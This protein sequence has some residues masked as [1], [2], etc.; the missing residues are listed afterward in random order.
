MNKSSQQSAQVSPCVLGLKRAANLLV[1]PAVGYVNSIWLLNCFVTTNLL[2]HLFDMQ[3]C[4]EEDTGMRMSADSGVQIQPYR[5]ELH[6]RISSHAH[7]CV[8]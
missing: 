1:A 2:T 3:L 5:T 7:V 4:S 6:P 8:F